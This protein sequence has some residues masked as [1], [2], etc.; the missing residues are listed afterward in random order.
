[1][2]ENCYNCKNIDFKANF[3]LGINCT[4]YC[5]KLRYSYGR[6][7]EDAKNYVTKSMPF[8]CTESGA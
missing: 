3:E 6:T 2:N 1:M 4:P 8:E 5:E 7:F